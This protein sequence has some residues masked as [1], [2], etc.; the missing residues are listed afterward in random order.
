MPNHRHNLPKEGDRAPEFQVETQRGLISFPE[1]AQ[2]QWCILFAHPANFT[3]AWMMFNTFMVLKERWFDE[4]N[5]KLIGVSCEP[6]RQDTWSDK[7]RRYIDIYLKAP[8]IEDA[9]QQIAKLYGLSVGRRILQE[10]NRVAFIIDPEGII[11]LII[12]RPIEGVENMIS[13]LEFELNRLQG[14]IDT[15]QNIGLPALPCEGGM[16]DKTPMEQLR[17]VYFQRDSV[18]PN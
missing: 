18:H 17:P 7:V 14:K 13:K 4:R 10:Q 2:G 12:E 15:N 3:S 6:L 1:Y 9:D 8:L 11:R 16:T 5:T